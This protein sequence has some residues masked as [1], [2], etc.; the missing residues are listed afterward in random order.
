M[1]RIVNG[2]I[3]S[4]VQSFFDIK[5]QKCS[6]NISSVVTI[7]QFLGIKLNFN[8]IKSATEFR[9]VKTS[10]GKIVEQEQSISYEIPVTEKHMTESVSFRLKY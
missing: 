10:S 6:E 1:S 3:V 8:R 4:L 2:D 9:C 5:E 7:F